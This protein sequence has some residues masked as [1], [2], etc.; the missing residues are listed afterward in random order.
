MKDL[1]AMPWGLW[2]RQVGS[3]AR[4]EVKKSFLSKRALWIYLLALL[5]VILTAGHSIVESYRSRP[6]CSIPED[7][8]IFAGI[9]QFFYLRLGIYFGC[10]GIFTNLFRAEILERTM[11]YYFLAPLR[12]EVLLV[13]KYVSGM[14]AAVVLFTISVAASY[15]TIAAHFGAEWRSFVLQGAGL[16]QF[17]WYLV[18]TVLACVGY[19]AVFL[20]AGLIFKNPMI[21]AALF[22]VWEGINGFLPA[23]L[24]KLS[25][26]FY[27]KS[28]SPVQVPVEGPLALLVQNAE[29]TPAWL[30]IPGLLMVSVAILFL[31]ARRVQR[32]EVSYTE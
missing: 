16:N 32:L 23:F 29:P 27:L 3:V 30:A 26:T 25:V 14:I 31:A 2:A 1:S 12:R 4:L 5:P 21:P 20:I 22:M 17:V 19:G 6:G 9:F 28:L 15:L 10:V 8:M 13:G 18:V 7:T 24:Q 11:H